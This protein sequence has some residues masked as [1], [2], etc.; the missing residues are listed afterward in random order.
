MIK[1]RCL[2][3]NS[4][5]HPMV[6]CPRVQYF[7]PFQTI[8]DLAAEKD[9]NYMKSFKRRG[10][11]DFHAVKDSKL[12][13]EA[14]LK[15]NGGAYS[16]RPVLSR[17]MSRNVDKD[18]RS[19]LNIPLALIKLH[20]DTIKREETF[21]NG[22]EDDSPSVAEPEQMI[23][24][25]NVLVYSPRSKI[26]RVRENAIDQEDDSQD[27]IE[28]DEYF[29]M[30][31]MKNFKIYF[32]N[33]NVDNVIRRVNKYRAELSQARAPSQRP[34]ASIS[35]GNLESFTDGVKRSKPM[36]NKFGSL[37]N[38]AFNSK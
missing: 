26:L 36:R 9:K 27:R 35:Y 10:K 38:W 4:D 20:S 22:S 13:R 5:Q 19:L 14:A 33:G 21:N 24:L 1:V 25:S 32:I 34:K 37:T 3:C 18:R 8:I 28:K 31:K 12:V 15:Y 2:A 16:S 17:V 30:D 6:R 7:P 11:C 29:V 23:N